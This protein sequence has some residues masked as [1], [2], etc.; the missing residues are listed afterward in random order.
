MPFRFH[1][2]MEGE[3]SKS[4][5]VRN[6]KDIVGFTVKS[7]CLGFGFGVDGCM[8]VLSSPIPRGRRPPYDIGSRHVPS[9]V[10]ILDN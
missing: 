9:F 8:D 7:S 3:P 5:K 2:E 4:V 1:E 6:Y 10:L